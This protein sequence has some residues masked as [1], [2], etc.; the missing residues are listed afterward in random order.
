MRPTIVKDAPR[1]VIDAP[2]LDMVS[3]PCQV[4]NMEEMVIVQQ[5]RG[6][7]RTK[8]DSRRPLGPEKPEWAQALTN[9]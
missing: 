8:S 2:E 5:A 7:S 6:G 1:F 3:Q 4:P 9:G